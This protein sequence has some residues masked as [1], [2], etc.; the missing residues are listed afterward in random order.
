MEMQIGGLHV[1]LL[2]LMPWKEL[3]SCPLCK[4]N[5]TCRLAVASPRCST[6]AAVRKAKPCLWKGWEIVPTT[7]KWERQVSIQNGF[8]NVRRRGCEDQHQ[9]SIVMD[10]RG[11][12][13]AVD[14]AKEKS[15][16]SV[17]VVTSRL[18]KLHF[19]VWKMLSEWIKGS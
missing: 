7:L 15:L 19:N 16:E 9:Q 8:E 14:E 6:A 1:H 2:G 10:G 3:A 11:Y 4:W 12:R 13:D 17:Q 18:S 5:E